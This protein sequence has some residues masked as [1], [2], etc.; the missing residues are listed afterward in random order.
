[1]IKIHTA[2]HTEFAAR[3][4]VN[5]LAKLGHQA[6]IIDDINYSDRSLHI[7]Y[8]SHALKFMPP[9]YVV[10]NTEIAQSHWFSPEYLRRIKK[11]RAVWDYSE[12][13]QSR[14]ENPKKSIVTP[15]LNPQHHNGKDIDCLFYGWIEGS[16]R[17]QE[18]LRD[19]SKVREIFTV[20]NTVGPSMWD[21]LRR[22][23]VVINIHYYDDSPLEL[24][25][26]HEAVSHGCK[27]WLH[28]E[29]Q[30]ITTVHDNLE[31]LKQA[32]KSI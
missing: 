32:L 26:I 2:I 1:M 19:L 30:E 13:N 4:L 17:R 16:K 31:E 22:A 5:Q 28:E 9:N 7:I 12:R 11:A 3:H 29:S 21:L 20:T 27:V 6:Q 18:I 8:D 14:Y 23:K 25:R 15:G 24:Y 10:M